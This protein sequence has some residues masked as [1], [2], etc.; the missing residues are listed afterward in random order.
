M[1]A[2]LSLLVSSLSWSLFDLARKRLTT[3][4]QPLPLA[5]ALNLGVLPLYL[6]L[7]WGTG[8]GL[9]RPGYW[10]PGLLSVVLA[11]VAAVA[12]MAALKAG[13]LSRLIP[14]LA[15]T[16]VI[17]ALAGWYWLGESL[18]GLQWLAMLVTVVAISGIQGG[19]R[20]CGGR[21]FLLM[22]LV[23]VCFG[24]V[25]VTDKLALQHGP[26]FWHGLV[27]SLGISLVLGAVMLLR[28]EPV[29]HRELSALIPALMVFALAVLGQWYALLSLEA[30]VVELVKRS[31]G[32]I[33]ALMLGRLLFA[34][35]VR[36]AQVLW[37]ILTIGMITLMLWPGAAGH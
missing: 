1:T 35:Q 6:V 34:E 37:S 18:S 14:V 27:Q 33:G 25:V 4:W 22:L 11:S 13:E 17:S 32:I 24:L 16:P 7:W 21:P 9:A 19:L 26:L 31:T 12:F 15:V 2:I 36:P 3:S 5:F 29:N 10:L 28:R 8:G 30:G 23:A 20:G